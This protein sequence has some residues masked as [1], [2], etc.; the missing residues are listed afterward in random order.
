MQMLLF[1]GRSSTLEPRMNRFFLHEL[2][3]I[4]GSHSV[5][6]F[7]FHPVSPLPLPL[8]I[9]LESLRRYG[10]CTFHHV[11]APA[12]RSSPRTRLVRKGRG[13]PYDGMYCMDVISILDRFKP[14]IMRCSFD[15]LSIHPSISSPGA[16]TN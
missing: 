3:A 12:I 5:C 11:L 6:F 8:T 15:V 13:V 9:E 4:E 7:S 16:S 10:K 1:Q 14:S 2:V